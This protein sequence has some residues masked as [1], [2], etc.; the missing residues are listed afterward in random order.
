MN[1]IYIYIYKQLTLVSCCLTFPLFQPDFLLFSCLTNNLNFNEG[2][3]PVFFWSNTNLCE[4]RK[5]INLL[6][7][8][9]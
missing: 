5:L 6:L 3:P 1:S 2:S 8:K 9:N 7:I 4:T